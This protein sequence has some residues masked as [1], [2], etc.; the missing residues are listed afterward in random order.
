MNTVLTPAACACAAIAATLPPSDLLTY[1]IHMPWLSK[2][3]PLAATAL[4]GGGSLG[5][6]GGCKAWL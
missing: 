4:T 5:G 3:V 2:A 1:Q 6:G